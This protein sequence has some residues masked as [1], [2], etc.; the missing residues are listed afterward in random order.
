[1]SSEHLI[2]LR[3]LTLSVDFQLLT[4]F[5]KY[6][7]REKNRLCDVIEIYFE[8]G[9]FFYVNLLIYTVFNNWGEL[10]GSFRNTGSI[11]ALG[12][13]PALVS[14]MHRTYQYILISTYLI[15]DSP[16]VI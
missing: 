1:M 3:V 4:K 16:S 6:S 9:S 8:L 2:P 7:T 15:R 14:L 12:S 13:T 11:T 10:R 5:Y